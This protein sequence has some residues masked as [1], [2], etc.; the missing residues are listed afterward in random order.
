[1]DAILERC[2]GLD[3]HQATIVACDL[4][5]PFASKVESRS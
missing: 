5:G 3:V 1:M 4:T 2:C